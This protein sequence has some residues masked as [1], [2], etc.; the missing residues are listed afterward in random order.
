M[1]IV[2]ALEKIAPSSWTPE[3]EQD[4]LDRNA[5][6]RITPGQDA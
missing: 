1:E 4:A 5:K 2:A 3:L 6:I